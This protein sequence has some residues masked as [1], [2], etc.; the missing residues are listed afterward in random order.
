MDPTA[1]IPTPNPVPVHPLWFEIL[2]VATFVVHL[3]FMN[4]ALGATVVAVFSRDKGQKSLASSAAARDLSYKIPGTLAL[5]VN[6]GVAPLLFLQV[7]YAQFFYPSSMMLAVYK[8]AVIALVIL[9]YYFLYIY[10]FKFNKLQGGKVFFS[11]AAALLLLAVGFFFTN[12]MTLMITPERW[13]AH[14]DDSTGR[15]LNLGEPTLFPRFLHFM[16]A[17][18]AVGGLFTAILGARRTKRG[19]SYGETQTRTG[20][21]WFAWATLAQVAVGLWFLI[22]LPQDILLLIMGGHWAFTVTFFAAMAGAVAALLFGFKRLVGPATGALVFTVSVMAILRHLVRTAYLEPFF[23]T[24]DLQV[25]SQYSPLLLFL[26]ALAV[27]L[28]L[29][30]Y[31]IKL[32]LRAAREG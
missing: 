15:F 27:G 12:N 1:L 28:I 6:F 25:A 17:S 20:M 22:T 4:T 30:A 11:V 29:V 14:M 26:A 13:F 21:A 32:A 19:D 3:L 9:A 5:A 7:L 2:L 8:L 16:T 10:D 18:L 24:S 23:R 31:M